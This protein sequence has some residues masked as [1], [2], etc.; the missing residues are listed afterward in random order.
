MVSLFV[1]YSF[2]VE[3]NIEVA[4]L[5]L[6]FLE[7]VAWLILFCLFYNVLSVPFSK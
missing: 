5:L 6:K 3:K 7:A 2:V 4:A 1:Y